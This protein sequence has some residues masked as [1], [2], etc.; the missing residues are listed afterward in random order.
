M[1]LAKCHISERLAVSR[2]AIFLLEAF[3][4]NSWENLEAALH[5][6]GYWSNTLILAML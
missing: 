4:K 6:R 5:T 2:S 3:Y 1:P